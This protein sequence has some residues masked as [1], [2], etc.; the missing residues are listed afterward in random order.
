MYFVRTVLHKWKSHQTIITWTTKACE[1]FESGKNVENVGGSLKDII[2]LPLHYHRCGYRVKWT[3]KNL[4]ESRTHNYHINSSRGRNSSKSK[5]ET[6]CLPL[7]WS[8]RCLFPMLP[9]TKWEYYGSYQ[10][11]ILFYI[12]YGRGFSLVF[13]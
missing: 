13:G 1:D 5:A 8:R 2:S 11:S 7:L 6:L 12:S 3:K 10:D 4:Q 9:F